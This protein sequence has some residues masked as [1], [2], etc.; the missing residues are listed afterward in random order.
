MADNKTPPQRIYRQI[1]EAADFY[2]PAVYNRL[3]QDNAHFLV[4]PDPAAGEF[5]PISQA[6]I[7]GQN[8]KM[9]VVGILP[10]TANVTGNLLD[11]SATTGGIHSPP[12]IP[13]AS[14]GLPTSAAGEQPKNWK[15]Y[16]PEQLR[17]SLAEAYRMH[18]GKYPSE[19]QLALMFAQ[20]SVE[21]GSGASAKSMGAPNYNLG[22]VHSYDGG[23]KY[24]DPPGTEPKLPPPKDKIPRAPKKS[25]AVARGYGERENSYFLGTDYE[26]AADGSKRWFYVY[27]E[28]YASLDEAALEQ[29]QIL[30][31]NGP[32]A[33][34]PQGFAER[35]APNRVGDQPGPGA[36]YGVPVSQYAAGLRMRVAEYK[37][38][39]P[40]PYQP[41]GDGSTSWQKD[42]KAAAST[43]K[44]TIDSTAGTSIDLRAQTLAR[45]MDAQAAAIKQTQAK[46]EDMA[47]MP[48][49]RLIVN[50][51]SFSVSS[52]KL[53]S[54]GNQGRYG[55]IVEH[56]GD[57]QDKIEGS[58]KIAAF[59]A[60]DA[61]GGQGGPGL[62]RTARNLSESYRNLMSLYLIYKNNGTLW[63]DPTPEG[64]D[65]V[66][67]TLSL[68]GS[69]YIYYDNTL[70]IGSFDN[71]SIN[72]SDDKPF[73]LDYS[74]N[75][76]VRYTFLLDN[77]E[78]YT[79]NGKSINPLAQTIPTTTPEVEGG[80]V[81]VPKVEAG[82]YGA[83]GVVSGVFT[84]TAT[85]APLFDSADSATPA[86]I[87]VS[88][89]A[90]TVPK[91][92]K[93]SK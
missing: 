65:S 43:A 13:A 52:E 20:V 39:F 85:T 92:G 55:P 51:A 64:G 37:K 22:S 47:K 34:T 46:I 5:I 36:Y 35:L 68:V 18:Y 69:V 82:T 72:E 28:S 27:F 11:R 88:S 40:T 6:A 90:I 84:T 32:I 14:A 63:F 67:Q 12:P 2:G 3:T 25:N 71:F 70:Y 33:D 17:A 21:T 30:G 44:E 45:L 79:M 41:G 58:G 31:R 24:A 26:L 89:P 62:T 86:P 80:P 75:F 87:G 15:Q 61:N 73:T 54:D 57:Q 48:P 19:A 8:A 49:L 16:T 53:V 29:V 42:G 74:F 76:T 91:K 66:E 9:F 38:R 83:L 1:E 56:W 78:A 59:Y 10:P 81:P 7:S 23:L 4:E 93:G 77:V 50:P 60:L